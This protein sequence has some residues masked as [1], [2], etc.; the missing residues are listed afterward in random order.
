VSG[1]VGGIVSAWNAIR[2]AAETA[3]Q[4][5]V[6]VVSAVT[7]TISST[8]SGIQSGIESVWRAIQRAGEAVWQPI[9]A[10]AS[11]A[12]GVIQGLIDGVMSAISGI[13]S[14]IQGA[15]GW[16]GDL[17][18][19]ITGAGNAAAAVPGGTMAAGPVVATSSPSLARAGL[20]GAGRSAPASSAGGGI[21]IVVN[22]AL[23]PD[24]V[25]RQIESLLRGRGRRTGGVIL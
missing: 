1:I 3:W 22:G 19:K 11:A 23:D 4:A 16:A 6:S 7:S 8:V 10:A 2:S 17:L 20:L 9:Q 24:A 13:G 5:I 12:M 15:I 21:S 14:A 18:G 25:A